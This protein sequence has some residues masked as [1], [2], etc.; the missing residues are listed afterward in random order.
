MLCSLELNSVLIS[1]AMVVPF[2]IEIDGITDSKLLSCGREDGRTR[3]ILFNV[4]KKL[5]FNGLRCFVILSF[6]KREA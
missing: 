2:E 6:R 3:K 1:V 4:Q 5:D